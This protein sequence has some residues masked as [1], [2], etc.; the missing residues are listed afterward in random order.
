LGKYTDNGDGTVT[1]TSTGLTWQ[2]ATPDN[3]MTWGEAMSY[4]TTLNLGNYKD[5]RLPTIKELRSLADYSRYNPAIN[6]TFFPDT[7]SSFYWSSTTNA[8]Y[9]D[10]AWGVYFYYGDVNDYDKNYG[11]YVRAVRGGQGGAL[12]PPVPDIKA[13]GQDGLITVSSGTPVSITAS[14][15]PGNENGK[16]ADWWLAYYSSLAGWYSLNSNGWTPG[17]NLLAQYPLFIIS[18]VEIYSASLPVGDYA[19]YFLVDMSTNGIVDS[20]FY[21]DF[22]QVHVVN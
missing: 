20:P 15:A 5:W 12:T 16:L 14:L 6:T 1:D 9:N 4:C 2:Q 18:P 17:I 3:S 19:F 13:N 10:Y 7:I 21:Y 8:S 11:Y 22:V